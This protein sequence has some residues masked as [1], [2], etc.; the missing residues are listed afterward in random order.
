MYIGGKS[1]VAPICKTYCMNFAAKKP[2]SVFSAVVGLFDKISK[3][4][5]V[6]PVPL[7]FQRN[8]VKA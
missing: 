4:P 1:G 6:F 8:A 5:N 7:D 2:K 3:L